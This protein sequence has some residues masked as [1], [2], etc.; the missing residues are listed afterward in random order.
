MDVTTAAPKTRHGW[1]A[2]TA[3]LAA[4]G[5]LA[6]LAV[7]FGH[8]DAPAPVLQDASSGPL[9]AHYGTLIGERRAICDDVTA[10]ARND[11]R[12]GVGG[13][14][15]IQGPAVVIV[16]VVG[17]GRV[18]RIQQQA[19][20]GDD[21][22]SWDLPQTAPADSITIVAKVNGTPSTCQIAPPSYT[23]S[24]LNPLSGWVG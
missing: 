10:V 24:R 21:V 15:N 11:D 8:V 17:N 19:T 22:V 7:Y 4:I 23:S 3:L 5:T 14:V 13:E 20:S 9:H 12:Q 1:V 2:P 16:T 18:R 6:A